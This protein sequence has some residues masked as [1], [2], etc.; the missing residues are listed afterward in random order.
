M[1]GETKVINKRMH[2]ILTFKM[3]K[4]SIPS[5]LLLKNK[6]PHEMTINRFIQSDKNAVLNFKTIFRY[7]LKNKVRPLAFR[8][9]N[10]N[11]EM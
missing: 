11:R 4:K 1:T 6:D 7:W 3:N 2:E 9:T 5:T 10:N 8:R